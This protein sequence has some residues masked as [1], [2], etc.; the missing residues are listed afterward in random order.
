MRKIA[1]AVAIFVA[2]RA[3]AQIKHGTVIILNFSKDEL[4]VAADS[5]GNNSN[6]TAPPDD[7]QCKIIQLGHK[8]LFT[9]SGAVAAAQFGLDQAWNNADIA[10]DSL[11]RVKSANMVPDIDNVS[12]SWAQAVRN[13]WQARFAVDRPAVLKAAEN[14][15]GVLTVGFFAQTISGTIRWILVLITFGLNRT[16]EVEPVPIID[17][18]TKLAY[19]WSCGQSSSH[20][21]A[22]GQPLIADSFCAARDYQKNHPKQTKKHQLSISPETLPTIIVK[23]TEAC[24]LKGFVGGPIDSVVLS[25]DGTIHWLHRKCNCTENYD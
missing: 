15:S 20:I 16:P 10:I 8:M 12:A 13:R 25:I 18:I 5:R 24:D 22:A 1:I 6:S 7:T 9:T 23:M 14:N 3:V 11:H 17:D 21:C 2:Y 4:I 19:C